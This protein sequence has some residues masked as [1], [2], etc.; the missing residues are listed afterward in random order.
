MSSPVIK[1]KRGAYADLPTL[2]IGE[3]GF[4]TDRHQ[5]YVGSSSGNQ[6]VGGG[7]FWNLNSTTEGG[8]IKLYEATNNGTNYIELQSPDSLASS[9][10]YT[11]PGT[12]GGADQVLKTDGAGNLTF[13]SVNTL[14]NAGLNN[15][16]EDT[17][18]Q[19]GGNLDLNSK[20]I[21]GTGNFNIT[22]DVVA[23][24]DL[25]VLGGNVVANTTGVNVSGTLTA[26]TFSGA[27]PTT[28]LTGTITNDQLAGSIGDNKLN[29][30]STANKISISALDIDGGTDISA[31]V[32]DADLFI[33]DDGANGA[34]RK[35]TAS[36]IKTYVLGAGE[37]ASFS[38]VTVGS[39]TTINASGI[40][41]PVGV[42]TAS[43][44]V[45]DVTGNADTSTAADTVKTVNT[46]VVNANHYI[47]FVDSDNGTATAEVVKTDA[48]IYYNPF[49]NQFTA[50]GV[51]AGV[52]SL[53][54]VD[55][56]STAVELNYL[57]GSTPGTASAGNALVLNSSRNITN[58]NA[59]TA[60]AL[61][62]TLT[63]NVTGNVTGNATSSD[64]VDVTDASNVNSSYNINFSSSSGSAKEIN[65]SNNL[66][67]NPSA[68][69]LT[70]GDFIGDLTGNVN[71]GIVTTSSAIVNGNIIVTG[72]VDG[73]DVLDDGQAGDNL[74]TLTGVARDATNLG[75]FNGSTVGDAETIKG[76]IQ[77]LETSLETVAGGG[78]LAASVAVGSTDSDSTHFINF[79]A[80]NNADPTQEQIRTDGDFN[81][82]PSTNTLV[83]T[84]ITGN[85][86]GIVTGNVTGDLTGNVTG[87]VTGNATSSDTVDVSDEGS[88]ATFYPVFSSGSGSGKTISRDSGL[89]YNPSSNTLTTGTFSGALSGNASSSTQI[90]TQRVNTNSAH[91]LTFVDGDN[92]SPNNEDLNTSLLATFN[93]SD[94]SLVANKLTATSNFFLGGTEVT[95]TATELNIL[96][97]VTAFLDEDNM[98]SNSATSIPSQ[99]SVKAYVDTEIAGVA[100]TFSLAAD[101]GTSDIFQTGQV[102]T[103][104]GTAD[105]IVTNVSD[106]KFTIALPDQVV[107]G[108]SLTA[109]TLYS[110]TVSASDGTSALTIADS[111]GKITG[112]GD[113]EVQG[114][115]TLQALSAQGNVSLGDQSSD[116]ISITGR[117]NTSIVPST[118]GERQV[119]SNSLRWSEVYGDNFVGSQVNVSGA[120]TVGTLNATSATFT[121]GGFF[122]GNVDISGNLSVGGSITS[123]NVDDFKAVSPLIEVGLEDVG[124]G[125]FQPPSFQTQ[126]STG[127]AMWYNTVGVS[128]DNAQAA[129]IFASVRPGGSFRIG[130]ATEV[131]FAGTGTTDGVASVTYWADIEAKGLWIN[132]CA[133]QSQ[134]ISC[135]GSERFLNNITVDGG[136]FS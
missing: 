41:A 114:S 109:P 72:T 89:S 4:T 65:Q 103:I 124:D 45:G 77:D 42:I 111:T 79:V 121:A 49:T 52:L 56:T 69:Q 27:L 23:S 10:S 134:V 119:G 64:T 36:R 35:T 95:S 3:P 120:A 30:I 26:T 132:D 48:G 92:N 44:F 24:G 2:E 125:T 78:A 54:S 130:F 43:S 90:K 128:S 94:G 115:T 96:D 135:E 32:V 21:T 14:N 19:L 51:N 66:T 106:N 101:T 76:A 100:V 75:T 97:G 131:S 38:N 8:G 116:L 61:N 6:L 31:A 47:T 28:D 117:V 22:G 46:P 73:R 39:A 118:D 71:A 112:A 126:Y 63:G 16:V 86:T 84:N 13:A 17:T 5:L 25:S 98:S 104:S 1:F 87:D 123:I 33:V 110:S 122:G 15:V 80:D 82:N 60:T 129:A 57:D 55:V 105:E 74:V 107:V 113:L 68:N 29:T 37:G 70:A 53:N 102:L 91:Y 88:N 67:Y 7:E 59:L 108:T 127:V 34:N 99:Q 136:S 50:N 9:L 12:D 83:V 133:G 58:I 62:G 85:L 40:D 20:N 93:P 81:Y 11:L 18:P